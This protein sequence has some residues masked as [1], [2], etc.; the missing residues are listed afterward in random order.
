[1]KPARRPRFLP[2]ILTGAVLGFALGAAIADFG[3]LEDTDTALAQNQYSP[4]AAIGYLGLLGAA[5]LALVA[6]LVA[7]FVERLS[8]RP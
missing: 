2:F 6:A 7:L 3:W 1:M 5:L 8:R 4:T